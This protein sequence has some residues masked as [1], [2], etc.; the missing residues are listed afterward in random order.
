MLEY[1]EKDRISWKELISHPFIK[2]NE[3]NIINE[4]EWIWL[5]KNKNKSYI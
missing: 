5:G 2:R 1:E 3:I 4:K